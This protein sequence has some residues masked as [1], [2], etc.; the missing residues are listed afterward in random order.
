MKARKVGPLLSNMIP[1]WSMKNTVDSRVVLTGTSTKVNLP[2]S[3]QRFVLSLE[4][5]KSL[6]T[7]NGRAKL[8]SP[9]TILIKKPWTYEADFERIT[10]SPKHFAP[11][12]R[13]WNGFRVIDEDFVVHPRGL[14]REHRAERARD[15]RSKGLLRI[16]AF[17]RLSPGL[18]SP[19]NRRLVADR[20]ARAIAH[21]EDL[22]STLVPGG[23]LIPFPD[24]H[25]EILT[26]HA[27]IRRLPAG[28]T[29][30]DRFVERA[31]SELV[32]EDRALAA[33]T[34]L[35]AIGEL[36]DH[37]IVH[38]DLG[39]RSVWM[40]GATQQALTG[41]MACQMP[42]EGSVAPWLDELRFY[43][44]PR[45]QSELSA[46]QAD[47]AAAARLALQIINGQPP[48]TMKDA[49]GRLPAAL[50]SLQPW[51][52][53][54]LGFEK[55]VPF[56]DGRDAADEL[57]RILDT[58]DAARVDQGL[59]DA[60]ETQDIPIVR[61]PQVQ[62]LHLAGT[63]HVWRA[64]DPATGL[65]I[66]VKVWYGWRRGQSRASDLALMR[67][68]QGISRI[69]Q[70]G[71]PD[72]P[73]F[74][75]AG[76][77]PAGAFVAYAEARGVPWCDVPKGENLSDAVAAGAALVRAVDALHSMDLEHGDIAGRNIVH[78]DGPGELTLIDLFD[79][80]AVGDGRV[81]G[82]DLLPENAEK[83]SLREIDRYAT[84]RLVLD[85]LTRCDAPTA[86]GL[87][88][89]LEVE[90]GRDKIELLQPV[91]HLLQSFRDPAEKP[92]RPT[93]ELEAVGASL[94]PLQAEDAPVFVRASA[95]ANGNIEYRVVGLEREL[96]IEEGPLGVQQPR[97]RP[98]VF[99]N[100]SSASRKGIAIELDI[101][102]SAQARDGAAELVEF[103]RP[104][105]AV[106][107]R[108]RADEREPEA[109]REEAALDVSRYWRRLIELEE[110]QQPRVTI[111]SEIERAG[112]IATY[113]YERGGID[114]D[115]DPD[116][117]VDVRRPGGA[118]I[119][120]LQVASADGRSLVI[121]HVND[122]RLTG[123]DQVLL[124]ER[125]ARSSFD[126]RSRAV[127]R[128]LSNEAGITNLVNY[129][130]PEQEVTTI[131]YGIQ[132]TDKELEPYRL[133]P[134]QR[135]AFRRVAR[136]GPVGLQQG[137]PGT[138]KT[139]F[140]AA[141]V[142]WLVTKQRAAKILIASQSHEAVNKAI[143]TLVDFY[144]ARGGPRPSLLRIGSKG[145]TDK[146]R[147]FHTQALRERYQVRFETAFKHRVVG[148]ASALGIRRGLAQDAVDLDRELGGMAR[149][150]AAHRAADA[151]EGGTVTAEEMRR[152]TRAVEA[153]TVTFME[154]VQARL[155][156]GFEDRLPEEI[157][158]EAFGALMEG[159]PGASPSDIRQLRRIIDLASD[160][161]SSLTSPHRNF[162]EFLAKTR[163]VVAATCVG[164][165]QTKIRIDTKSFDWVIIDEAARCTA[166]ELAIP[167]QVGQRILLV[168]D[169]LQLNPMIDPSVFEA[170]AAEM[171]GVTEEALRRSDFERAFTSSY[172]RANGNTLTEQYRMAP[173]ICDLVS[174]VFY[175]PSAVTLTTS[176][177]RIPNPAFADLAAPFEQPAIWVDT[178]DMPDH[179]EKRFERDPTT[180][181]NPTEVS[182]TM[183]LLERLAAH[184]ALI[185]ALAKGDEAE[186]IGIICMYSGQK[187]MVDQA[188]SDRAWDG[189][190]RRMVR[191]DTVDS[192]QG[193]ENTVIILSLVRS[194]PGLR[195]GHVA[196]YNRCNV[197][198]SRAKERLFILGARSM[199]G[200]CDPSDP[201]R[202]VFNCFESGMA[203]TRILTATDL[204]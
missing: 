88:A 83:L 131:D 196:S 135:E 87:V 27:E 68:L 14:W 54:A 63:K 86:L 169:H 23:V 174:T 172:G 1:N 136:Y 133:N 157:V 65:S 37:G 103:I 139:R 52:G 49:V 55:T 148:I 110:D 170:M 29:T 197:A 91:L 51:F 34:L 187:L 204:A 59:L 199:W 101:V 164:V 82:G 105:V 115:F 12:E 156:Q 79:F 162:E 201:M 96:R 159:H 145:I 92:S 33:A 62:Q 137:P 41:F 53:R 26:Q 181:W 38:R 149:R 168:G 158:A 42:N 126:R 194:N 112:N 138:G 17:D 76:L 64:L 166:S 84:V 165:G 190:F 143:E 80:S 114:F 30:L 124:V 203:G 90:C 97:V 127:E 6:G 70:A 35:N 193:K 50:D 146:I 31:H 191:I 69:R 56:M 11:L 85:R 8:L 186:P 4:E 73:T 5:A 32:D 57:G 46:K 183:R 25:D 153:M 2:P 116:E 130:T 100:L 113:T 75:G 132:V 74:V 104:L 10:R 78:R 182:L 198:L 171:D 93:F 140:I 189:R 129:F 163:T 102:I 160:W 185:S 178:G 125:R 152:N 108:P 195:R 120:E 106:A 141:F 24:D 99:K 192:Y 39:E 89:A 177:D 98:T 60:H 180:L 176:A 67:L 45:G 40:G 66:I 150:I 155:G 118:R 134:G 72:L 13:L 47:V 9:V 142:H 161:S 77:S 109:P 184:E 147:P 119:G 44:I 123:G 43:A 128:V 36:H 58:R 71:R 175:Q 19:E 121:R 188:F 16:W 154:A 94:G 15:S 21:L 179:R 144:K 167:V 48:E 200:A 202:K 28:W 7:A 117:Q 111:V 61:W 122:R 151:N 22:K 95:L 20:E 107:A 18:N 173:P 3:E 81:I